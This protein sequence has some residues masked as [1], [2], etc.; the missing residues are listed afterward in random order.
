MLEWVGAAT[1]PDLTA[2]FSR[3]LRQDAGGAGGEYAVALTGGSSAA[4]FYDALAAHGV[5]DGVRFFW[6]DERLVPPTDPDSNFKLAEDHL[7]CPAD[8][9]RAHVFPAPTH[10]EPIACAAAYAAE[11]RKRVPAGE[12]G[13]PRFPL[14]ILG[15]GEDGHTGSLFPKHDPYQDDGLLVR[16]V[17]GT[18]AHPHPRITFTPR[19]INAAAQ[20]WFVI[21]GAKKNWAVEQLRLR[22]AAPEQVPSLAVDPDKTR[23]AVFRG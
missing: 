16:A 10:L 23:I 1:L 18:T 5:P 21:T 12:A 11:I 8:V 19:L 22:T 13:V 14:I 15:L 20:V 7:L 17:D 3:R 4:V 6:S 9:P 2:E